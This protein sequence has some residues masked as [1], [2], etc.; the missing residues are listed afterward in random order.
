MIHL[1]NELAFQK[2]DITRRIHP[3][4]IPLTSEC[5][6]QTPTYPSFP[7]SRV[8]FLFFKEKGGADGP[9]SR[10]LLQ[11]CE[12]PPTQKQPPNHPS[13]FNESQN[14]RPVSGG[15]YLGRRRSRIRVVSESRGFVVFVV[16]WEGWLLD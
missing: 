7:L 3:T 6:S 11:I 14:S 2:S 8:R 9:C 12:C 10:P 16:F 13:S 4:T 1:T 5:A 15:C